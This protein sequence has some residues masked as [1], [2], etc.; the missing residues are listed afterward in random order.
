AA[1]YDGDGHV[2]LFVGGRVIPW[3]Y[4]ANPRSMLLHNDGRG[5]FTNVTAKLAPELEQVGMVTDAVWRDVDGDGRLDLIVVG[6]WMPITIFHNAGNGRLV[7]L[8]VPGLEKSHGWWNRIIAGDFT[9]SGRVD[10]IVG[11]AGLNFR[12]RASAAEPVTMYVK[13]FDRNGF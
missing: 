11:N 1:D 2:D 10:F 12:C 6:E 7:K 5:H 8:T 4:G 3:A 13:D 9:G